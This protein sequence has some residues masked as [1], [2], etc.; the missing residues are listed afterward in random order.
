MPSD[1]N[2]INCREVDY[3]RYLAHCDDE[4][5]KDEDSQS[6]PCHIGFQ[7]PWLGKVSPTFKLPWSY[8]RHGENEHL[9]KDKR[10]FKLKLYMVDILVKFKMVEKTETVEKILAV[11]YC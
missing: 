7:T 8:F 11:K 3:F 1:T 9:G 5:G 4:G 6:H 10:C 2:C